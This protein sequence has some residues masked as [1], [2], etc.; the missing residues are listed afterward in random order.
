MTNRFPFAMLV[1][2]LVAAIA[3]GHAAS[4]QNGDRAGEIQR[5]L[6]EAW[7]LPPSPPLTP[8]KAMEAMVVQPGHRIELV[9]A[10][11]MI[12]DPV[13]APL[14]IV[15]QRR[16]GREPTEAALLGHMCHRTWLGRGSN[17]RSPGSS[18]RRDEGG[19]KG[20]SH[21]VAH[22]DTLI[23]FEL[24]HSQIIARCLQLASTHT[25]DSMTST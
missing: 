10:E 3:A 13:Q 5:D 12:G 24:S 6:P 18:G 9:A 20:G 19:G 7:R 17:N 1:G 14:T 25:N 23:P 16:H 4:A 21:R 11:P 2:S 8:E 15:R 22:A